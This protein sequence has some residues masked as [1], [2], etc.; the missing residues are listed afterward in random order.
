[1]NG[2]IIGVQG[3]Y[4]DI[5]QVR[6][7][8]LEAQ[9]RLN[10]LTTLY[11]ISQAAAQLELEPLLTVVGQKI[12]ETF[13]VHSSFIALY[14]KANEFINIPYMINKGERVSVNRLSLTDQAFQVK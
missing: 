6:K 1:M 2:E 4:W 5:T 11:A 10:E 3:I 12:E 7:A 9:E 8:T 14:D 13:Q